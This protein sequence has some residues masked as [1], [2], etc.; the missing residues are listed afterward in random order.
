MKKQRKKIE[1][2]SKIVYV[3]SFLLISLSIGVIV[4]FAID[5]MY[6]G[7]RVDS[8]STNIAVQYPGGCGYVDNSSGKSIFIPT[9]TFAEWDS[10]HD[11]E[12]AGTNGC[13]GGSSSYPGQT[14]WFYTDNNCGS[15]DYNCDGYITKQFTRTSSQNTDT[16]CLA[17]AVCGEGWTHDL[18]GIAACGANEIW[19]TG[20]CEW[21]SCQ[22]IWKT[23][24][25]R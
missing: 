12:P 20:A 2:S 15:W 17:A 5:S 1:I 25:C 10:F 24:A 14:G 22:A 16:F 3:I 9:Y 6:E 8:V 21:W 11:N 7:Y 19:L 23:Q 13:T 4:V 18:G